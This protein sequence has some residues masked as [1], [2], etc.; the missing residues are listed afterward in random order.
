M[1]E[2][3]V[4]VHTRYF[5]L[6]QSQTRLAVLAH[7]DLT[8]LRFRKQQDRNV[9]DLIFATALFDRDGKFVLGT[10]KRFELRL[11]DSTLARLAHTGITVKTEF[12]LKPG[13]YL[14]RQI[15]RDS[16]AGQLSELNHTVEI[17]Y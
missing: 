11:L 12:D 7:L 3:P 2:L 14:V 6:D 4:D 9:N 10:E 13:T 8:A 1:R 15:V 5:K 17:P 16:E